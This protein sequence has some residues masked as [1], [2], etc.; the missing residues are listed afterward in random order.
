MVV[1]EVATVLLGSASSALEAR[2][3]GPYLLVLLRCGTPFRGQ[4]FTLWVAHSGW[5]CSWENVV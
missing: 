3:L 5:P 2:A 1:S 4:P